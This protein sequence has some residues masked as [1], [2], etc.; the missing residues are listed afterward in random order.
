MLSAGNMAY[1]LLRS[2]VSISAFIWQGPIKP[3]LA[4]N[5]WVRHWYPGRSRSRP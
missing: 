3:I 4:D 1:R 5:R 2:L